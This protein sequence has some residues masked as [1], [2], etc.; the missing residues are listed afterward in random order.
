MQKPKS[1]IVWLK[2]DLRLRDHAALKAA[3]ESELPFIV[4]YIF[5]PSLSNHYDFDNR[6]WRFVYQSLEDL[7]RQGL[8]VYTFYDEAFSVFHKL[9]E[10]IEIS[11]I[12]SY[13]ETGV[14]LTFKRDKDLKRIFK[15]DN[16][17]WHEYQSNGVI[18]GLKNRDGWDQKWISFMLS[19]QI[20]SEE[21][22]LKASSL[23]LAW[24][25]ENKGPEL[26]VVITTSDPD[27]QEGGEKIALMRLED[28]CQ[29][30]LSG[31]IS[32]ISSPTKSRYYCSR[33][34]PH[35][36]W[37][38]LTIRQVYQRV[39]KEKKNTSQSKVVTQFLARLKWHCHFIQRF[40]MNIEME[41]KNLNS[42]FDHLRNK[43]D[44]DL[45]KAWKRARRAI[46]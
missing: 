6:H 29:N 18:R 32:H 8:K 3:A 37:G 45:L 9:S 5:E 22:F 24:Y 41:F 38:N 10:I 36:A 31:Y 35:I 7:K 19:E 26:P 28:F 13:Q 40:E 44:K 17:N 15:T 1:N 46:L 33:L 20:D 23:D 12:F 16:I 27:L 30:Q 42:G 43:I 14:E 4:I 21:Y 34:S 25:T 39:A 2:R 11:S